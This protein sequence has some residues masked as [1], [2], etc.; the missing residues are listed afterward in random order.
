VE[1]EINLL[2]HL[3]IMELISRLLILEEIGIYSINEIVI[4]EN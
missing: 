1:D 4:R 2:N 3:E